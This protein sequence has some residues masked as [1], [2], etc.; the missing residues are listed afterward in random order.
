MN[1]NPTKFNSSL[2]RMF[3]VY[4]GYLA[5]GSVA[6]NSLDNL[7]DIISGYLDFLDP[8][9]SLLNGE[10][11]FALWNLMDSVLI[12][13]IKW[14][15]K[16][17]DQRSL[18]RELI[19]RLYAVTSQLLVNHAMASIFPWNY[20][21]YNHAIISNFNWL[22][23]T[24]SGI[25][26]QAVYTIK[27]M[28]QIAKV[29]H[30]E[31]ETKIHLLLWDV[32]SGKTTTQLSQAEKD[33]LEHWEQTLDADMLDANNFESEDDCVIVED[34]EVNI[35]VQSIQKKETVKE[36][37]PK[38][39]VKAFVYT[40][41]KPAAKKP[42]NSKMSKINQMRSEMNN[43]RK[44][45]SL[46]VVPAKLARTE[47]IERIENMS[48]N[49]Y[50]QDSNIFDHLVRDMTPE[51]VKRQI[52]AIVLPNVQVGSIKT[53]T[54]ADQ[55]KPMKI[56]NITNIHKKILQ[57]EFPAIE[58][59]YPPN[60]DNQIAEIP[61]KFDTALQYSNIFEPFLILE[62][63]E[64]LKKAEGE[65]SNEHVSLT[66]DST[67]AVDG[68]YGI[69]YNY[70]LI[71]DLSFEGSN[72]EVRKKA[73]LN[74][75]DIIQICMLKAKT[76]VSLEDKSLNR[77]SKSCLAKINTIH[78]LKDTCTVTCRIY[79]L[80]IHEIVTSLRP[81]T[82]WQCLRI[83]SLTT[84]AREYTAITELP[85]LSLGKEILKPNF[86]KY[87]ADEVVVESIMNKYKTN[88]PQ[89]EAI[90]AAVQQKAGFILIQGP[91]MT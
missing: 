54:T 26:T 66:L 80:N 28:L 44:S 17:K 8:S 65:N 90:V 52:K 32:T 85:L 23:T 2:I 89:S 74:E 75:N 27:R 41:K 70:I 39:V 57:W 79:P 38:P 47:K 24:D 31:V 30:H 14:L 22:K 11:W 78:S 48:K 20:T 68:F 6:I 59:D 84:V 77:S 9:P 7:L 73:N 60:F 67:L 18:I 13:S 53:H 16:V 88:R 33:S 64:H 5:I 49:D 76:G 34:M 62:C 58:T 56:G 91:R 25:R 61:N 50:E 40:V 19:M 43:E 83:F 82:Q 63:W 4:T 35:P 3:K 42:C 45:M 55:P 81:S 29:M 1:L 86:R 36:F 87:K 12:S 71:L 51:K 37:Y 69:I 72:Y 10:L 15:H 21:I 46:N